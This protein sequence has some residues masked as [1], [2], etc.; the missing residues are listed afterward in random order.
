M[1]FWRTDIAAGIIL[2]IRFW[3]RML[4]D[5]NDGD[6]VMMEKF[7]YD[8]VTQNPPLPVQVQARAALGVVVDANP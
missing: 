5:G 1:K 3:E 6:S 8:Y 2:A 4:V 7:E